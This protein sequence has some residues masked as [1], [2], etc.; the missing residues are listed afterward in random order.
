MR[1]RCPFSFLRLFP[2][3]GPKCMAFEYDI[4]AE[5]KIDPC[6]HEGDDVLCEDC[7]HPPGNCMRLWGEA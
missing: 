6:P 3:I 1:L 5:C 7:E 2:C 4:N